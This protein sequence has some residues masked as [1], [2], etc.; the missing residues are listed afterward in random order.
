[1]GNGIRRLRCA[2]GCLRHGNGPNGESSGASGGC[3]RR[4][5]ADSAASDSSSRVASMTAVSSSGDS[6]RSRRSRLQRSLPDR[7]LGFPVVRR[8]G[9]L[10]VE[11]LTVGVGLDA[12]S[13]P[14]PMVLTAVRRRIRHLLREV[15]DQLESGVRF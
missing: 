14:R 3:G 6:R 13:S 11:G 5:R 1:M 9:L 12:E 4:R 10:G 15:L 7:R 8:R 2:H